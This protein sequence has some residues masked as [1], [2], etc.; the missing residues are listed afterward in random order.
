MKKQRAGF[1]LAAAALLCLS[2]PVAAMAATVSAGD[3][4]DPLNRGIAYAWTVN[5]NGNDTTAGSTPNYAGSVGSLSWNDPIN[6]GDP[7]GTGWT[8]TSNW[9]ALTLTE[10]ADLSVTLAANSSSLVPA[11]SLYAGQQQTDNGGNFGW[12]VYNNAGN[13][14]WSTADPA[15]DS[16]SLN[17]IGNEANLGGL[18]SITK[19]FSSLAAGDYTL[20]F[21]GNP[22]AGTAGS[23]VGY[24][25]TLT[26]AP[27]PVP[28]AVWLFGSGL[29]GVVAFARRRMS[30]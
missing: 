13:F 11:F 12:H 22:P 23:G 30:A 19:V 1:V 10:A 21:G 15:Y 20:I 24:Q 25:A 4:G 28:A 27:V 9:T 3:T 26:T 2:G 16:S 5:M 7:I 18:S 14:D 6:A 17:Y 8:H 29:A